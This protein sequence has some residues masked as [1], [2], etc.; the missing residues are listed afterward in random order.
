LNYTEITENVLSKKISV[1][2]IFP[3]TKNILIMS[4]VNSIQISQKYSEYKL[5]GV[6]KKKQL[7]FETAFI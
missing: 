1:K 3:G 4:L 2:K 7:H 6:Y 5:T